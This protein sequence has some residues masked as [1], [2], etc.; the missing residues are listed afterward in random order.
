MRLAITVVDPRSGERRD[1]VVEADPRVHVGELTPAF[2]Q[3]GARV[4]VDGAELDHGTPLGESPLREGAVISLH[5]ASGCVPAEPAGLVELRVVGG[6]GAG[7][8]HRLGVGEHLVG[9]HGSVPVTGTATV[10]VSVSTAAAVLVS[11]VESTALLEGEEVRGATL[12]GPGDLVDLGGALLDVRTPTGPDAVLEK[13]AG[14]ADDLVGHD[15]NRPP[16]ILPPERTTS[17]RLPSP[18]GDAPRRPFPVVAAIVPLLMCATMIVVT[19]NHRYLALGLL[20]PIAV[21]ANALVDRKHGRTSHR[22]LVKRYERDKAA[23]EADARAALVDERRDRRHLSADPAELLLTAVG[24]RTRLWERRRRD[25]DHLHVRLGPADLPSEV[26]LEDPEQLEHRRT[27]TW[28]ARNVPVTVSLAEHPVLGLAGAEPRRTAA[29]LL[30]QLAV[31]QS[32]RDVQFHVL[33][34]PEGLPAWEWLRWVPHARA[35]PGGAGGVFAGTGTDTWARRVAE[36]TAAVDQRRRALADLPAGA[37]LEAPDLVVVLDGARRLR[38][39]PGVVNL[40]ADGP[41][42]GVRL[43]CCDADRR[44]LPEECTA[45]VTEEQRRAGTRLR[46]ERQRYE[47]VRDVLA[48]EP[49]RGWAPRLARALAPLR[50]TGDDDSGAG[51]PGVSRLL[52][53]LG[54]EPPSPGAVSARWTLGGRSTVAVVGES[55]DGPFGFDLRADGPHGLVA[56]TTGSGKSELLQTIV[57]SLA[58]ANRPDAMTFV[59]VDYKG[60]AAFKDCVDLPHTVG[61]VTDLD[62]H[63]V[64]RALTSLGAEL[65]R[66]E[67]LLAAAGAKDLEDYDDLREQAAANPAAGVAPALP[68]LL[69]VIDEFASLARELP[70]FVTGLVDIA[71]R[72]RSLGIHLLLA[73]QRPTGVVS[74]EIRANTNLRIALRVTDAGESSDVLGAPDAARIPGSAPGRAYAKLGHGSLVP[75]QAGRVGGRRRAAAAAGQ[76]VPAPWSAPLRGED[77]GLPAPRRPRARAAEE[78]AAATDLRALVDAVRAASEELGLPRPASP[79]LPALGDLLDL[80]DVAGTTG[81][82]A[83]RLAAAFGVQDLPAQQRRAPLELDLERDGHLY[84]VGAPRSGRSQVLRTLAA[85][86]A[87]RVPVAD[88]HLHGLDCGGGALLA[89]NALPHTGAV[90]QRSEPERAVRLLGRLREE[91]LRRQ[92]ELGAIGVADITEQRAAAGPAGAD[93]WPH[94]V[95]LLDRW[96]GFLGGIAELDGQAPLEIVHLLL[97]EGAGVG[98]HLVVAGD[99]Q[100]LTGRTGTLVEDKLLLHLTDRADAAMAGLSARQVPEEVPAGRVLR[101]GSGV[102]AQVAVL[103]PDPSGPAQVAA[104]AALGER[105][106]ERDAATP[107]HRR[108]FHLRSLPVR[109]TWEE[110]REHADLAPGALFALVGVGGDDLAAAGCDLRAGAGTAVVAGP[111]RSGRSTVL[112]TVA[113]SLLEQGAELVVAAPRPSPLRELAGHPGVRAVLTGDDL[114]AAELEPVLGEAAGPVVLLVDDAEVLRTCS[115]DA[116]LAAFVARARSSGSAVVVAGEAGEVGAGFSNWQVPLRRN[117][118]G[119]LIAPQDVMAGDVVGARVPRSALGGAPNPGRVLLHAGDGELVPVQVPATTVPTTA[120]PARA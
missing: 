39:L 16:R 87:A 10:R 72:G 80:A 81:E 51:L 29:R 93:P 105:L 48:D 103:G 113:R 38:S 2:G 69:I 97:R 98:V 75:F 66:R 5:D 25:D 43:I 70:D 57:A 101:S 111:P 91:V 41:A 32:P 37:R 120:V 95:L 15:Y 115:T 17:F 12:W 117:R 26:T 23:V 13:S 47:T 107:R 77:L 8:V 59:L 6:A 58:V 46:L 35:E 18:P 94:V 3:A 96:E 88:L 67:H 27:V 86:L 22:E 11:A 33:T 112:L 49:P 36:L 7:A 42:L 99:R 40:L 9:P 24:P 83:G 52:D 84:V 21:V 116:W 19:Q 76:Q 44:S 102:E 82:P 31:L 68:R 79:W 34:S 60:G 50:D 65:H 1:V 56:G 109:L 90:V 110:A 114:S 71:Q 61:M 30:A 4:F 53:V 54:L 108:P 45:V 89:L 62:T 100:L 20:S 73:T 104:L 119:V 92:A 85:S 78:D 118:C 55:L 14:T 106:R 63:L 74:A 64:G 28:T